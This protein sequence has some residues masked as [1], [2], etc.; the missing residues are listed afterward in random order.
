MYIYKCRKQYDF[1]KTFSVC[2]SV[3]A[4]QQLSVGELVYNNNVHCLHMIFYI[5]NKTTEKRLKLAALNF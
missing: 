1:M 3:I 4:K 2:Y 5:S